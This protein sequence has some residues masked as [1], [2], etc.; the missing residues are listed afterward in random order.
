R[1][2]RYCW[3]SQQGGFYLR[4]IP[5]PTC[6]GAK[7]SAPLPAHCAGTE[8]PRLYPRKCAGTEPA[9]TELPRLYPRKNARARNYCE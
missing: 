8:L 1:G 3:L 2:E 6:A 5:A 7:L 9:G 4:L